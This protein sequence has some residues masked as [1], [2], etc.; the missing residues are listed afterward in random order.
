[1][2]L[3]WGAID[4]VDLGMIVGDAQTAAIKP[5]TYSKHRILQIPAQQD[6]M[7]ENRFWTQP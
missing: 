4:E 2:Y 1:M 3:D 6:E 7:E 5:R